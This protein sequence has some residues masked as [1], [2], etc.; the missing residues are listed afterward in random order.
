MSDV[1]EWMD[2]YDAEEVRFVRDKV[3]GMRAIIA[4]NDSTLG[5][6][7][8][9]V[10]MRPYATEDEA[11]F[12]VMRLSRAMTYKCGVVGEDYGGAKAVIWGDPATQKNE[13][14]LRSFGRFV[15]MMGDRFGTGVDLNLDLHDAAEIAKET[16]RILC[17]DASAESTGSSGISAA[18]GV[19]E[20]IKALAESV[21]GS[22]DLTGK[23][24]AIQG[25]GALGW[26]LA[27]H[28]HRAGC[29]L[30]VADPSAGLTAAATREHSATVVTPEA[31][32]D[33]PCDIFV[34]AAIGGVLSEATIPR[35]K[36]RIVALAAN[37]PLLDEEADEA[38]LIAQG[39]AFVPDFV[40][41]AGGVLQAIGELEGWSPAQIKRK[42][43]NVGNLTRAILE[44]SAASGQTPYQTARALVEERLRLIPLVRRT[45][46][47]GG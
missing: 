10:R 22:P 23:T 25:L 35:L 12:D 24:V 15:A 19:F 38:R 16:D 5:P 37:N 13:A 46:V 9:G 20:G 8:G 28:L 17:H 42:C 1:F 34:P 18:I 26:P 11:M 40:I 39:I 31:I 27:G 33:A 3:T 36:C 14:Y 32:Y 2:R 30:T 7:L 29:A 47:P 21:W 44:R 4:I 43:L 45:H 41:N 6:T